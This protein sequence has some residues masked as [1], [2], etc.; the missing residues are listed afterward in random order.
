MLN[1]KIFI[2]HEHDPLNR[3]QEGALE[4]KKQWWKEEWPEEDGE[5][6]EDHK[7][8][9]KADSQKDM[10]HRKLDIEQGFPPRISVILNCVC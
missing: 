5:N 3:G 2:E 9:G 1:K 4:R 10:R 7:G 8:K 6:T